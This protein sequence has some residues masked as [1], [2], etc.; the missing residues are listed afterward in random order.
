MGYKIINLN[1][2]KEIYLTNKKAET[3]ISEKIRHCL[4]EQQNTQK[5][6]K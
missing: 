3:E 5:L 1:N 2:G 4:N 6:Y